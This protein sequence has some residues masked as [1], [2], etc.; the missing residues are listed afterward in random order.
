MGVLCS[1]E[2]PAVGP[3]RILLSVAWAGSESR[4]DFC[5]DADR[6]IGGENTKGIAAD[7]SS[8]L[9]VSID[10]QLIVHK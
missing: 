5:R 1:S 8:F 10:T 7:T 4:E 2:G 9:T 6:T 3:G